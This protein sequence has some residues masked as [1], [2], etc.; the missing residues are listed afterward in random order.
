MYKILQCVFAN[1]FFSTMSSKRKRA[2]VIMTDKV[3][4]VRQIKN[5][6]ILPIVDGIKSKS[7]LIQY[8]T[9]VLN[10]K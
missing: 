4:A 6:E 1:L 5:C 2:V 9:K 3:E 8:F 10:S 7:K